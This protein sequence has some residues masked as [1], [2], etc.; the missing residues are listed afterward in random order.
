MIKDS[1]YDMAALK[2]KRRYEINKGRKNFTVKR[3]DPTNYDEEIFCIAEKAFSV[4]PEK[5]K[6]ILNKEK[7]IQEIENEWHR[8]AVFAAFNNNDIL[9]GYAY[10]I[11]HEEY[12]EFS[13]LKSDPEEEKNAI[14]A[15]IV[16][17]ILCEYNDLLRTDH[18]YICDGARAIRHQT[19]FQDYLE[20]YFGFRKSYCYLHIEYRRGVQLALKIASPFT[21]ILSKMNNGM[22]YNITSLLE[23]DSLKEK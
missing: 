19:H 3:I 14:N 2:S 10:L 20:K 13:V 8:Y 12:A 23:M 5:Y 16:D 7:F 1:E 17:G 11:N 6:P 4:Y 9:S 22:A 18:F 15:A 21:R